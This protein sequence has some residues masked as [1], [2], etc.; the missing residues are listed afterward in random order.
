MPRIRSE[1]PAA[2]PDPRAAFTLVELLL[3][4]AIIGILVGIALPKFTGRTREAR[5]TATRA[6][7][8][9]ISTAIRLYELDIGD[10]PR[11]LQELVTAPPGAGQRW[12]GPYLEKGMPVD[13]WSQNYIY[14]A[15][16]TRNPNGFDLHSLGPDGVESDDDITNWSHSSVAQP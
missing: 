8:E 5:I 15:P 9:S 14:A 13:P 6:D 4:V 12:K 11:T 2:G 3:V 10:F 7:I 1:R 16:G